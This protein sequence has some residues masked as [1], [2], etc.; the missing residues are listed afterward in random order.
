M[1]DNEVRRNNRRATEQLLQKP[2]YFAPLECREGESTQVERAFGAQ[3]QQAQAALSAASMG[4]FWCDIPSNLWQWDQNVNALFG[5][6]TPTTAKGLGELLKAIHHDDRPAVMRA[7]TRSCKQTGAFRI[8]FRVLWPDGSVRWVQAKGR[9]INEGMHEPMYLTGVL[10]DVTNYKHQ[11]E[12]LRRNERRFRAMSHAIPAMVWTCTADGREQYFNESWSRY[13]SLSEQDSLNGG[14]MSVLHPDDYDGYVA[15][16]RESLNKGEAYLAE[17]RF[18]H[19]GGKYRWHVVRVLP[20]KGCD[21][22]VLH[23]VAVAVDIEEHRTIEQALRQS[24]Q[25]LG[26]AQQGAHAGTWDWDTA[27]NR[28]QYS[29]EYQALYGWTRATDEVSYEDWLECVHPDDQARVN[30]DLREA[31]ETGCALNSEFRIVRPDG[32]IRWLWSKGGTFAD[33]Q[34]CPT[35]V[36]GITFDITARKEA[37]AYV[38]TLL[39]QA[40][41]REHDLREK[42]AQLVQAAKLAS[43]GELATGVAHEINNPLNNI[44]LCADNLID[45]VHAGIVNDQLLLSE[46]Q[47]ITAQVQKAARIV[48]HLRRF[49]RAVPQQRTA[50]HVHEV[51]QSALALMREQL[52]L[53]NIEVE[54]H[55]APEDPQVHGDAL[56]IE[57]VL[58]NL[59]T[60]A[61]DAVGL[62]PAKSITVSTAVDAE[63]VFIRVLDTGIG[64][65]DEIKKRIFDPFFTTKEVGKGTGLGLSLSYGIIHDH[66]GTLTV[67][68]QPGQGAT[69]VVQLPRPGAF[70]GE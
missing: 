29:S 25:A 50:I 53:R 64:M 47:L 18:R 43:I 20:G 56:Q 48:D 6:S 13:T 36:I 32:A 40:K 51:V 65:T 7:A 67:E 23:W 35:R 69:F 39:T 26:L 42:Q 49:G 5:R 55:W 14:W 3:H 38:I 31:A 30:D 66:R 41:Q 57:Q 10:M 63:W 34:G 4:A 52:R 37:E 62:T 1:G 60:N 19:H 46:L 9:T 54:T 28:L 11:E 44:G 58:L 33:A 8:D 16:W 59:L 68:S 12:C 17:S 45:A 61:R 27:S 22:T 70:D 15:R 21:G 2:Q 24:T